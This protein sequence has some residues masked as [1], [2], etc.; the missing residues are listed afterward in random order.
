MYLHAIRTIRSPDIFEYA[1]TRY[2]AGNSRN[3]FEPDE[4]CAE[5]KSLPRRAVCTL[6]ENNFNQLQLRI[7]PTGG[8]TCVS[9]SVMSSG[10][11][12]RPW[13]WPNAQLP[14][15]FRGFWSPLSGM[16]NACVTGASSYLL[17]N[18]LYTLNSAAFPVPR[19]RVQPLHVAHR[20][21]QTDHERSHKRFITSSDLQ[22]SFPP[23]GGR[24]DS[25]RQNTAARRQ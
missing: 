12:S 10:R 20:N 16:K 6:T 9:C 17:H 15:H 8:T 21:R 1:F 14:E 3:R 22:R 18:M 13:R 5:I 23:N 19:S 7:V 25:C 4:V 11:T 2:R 24:C